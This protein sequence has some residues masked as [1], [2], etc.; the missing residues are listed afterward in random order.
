MRYVIFL[1]FVS[2]YFATPMLY[3]VNSKTKNQKS[4]STTRRSL[5][6]C[7]CCV[8]IR[9][10]FVRHLLPTL[11]GVVL[12]NH[13]LLLSY[14]RYSLPYPT[15]EDVY[16]IPATALYYSPFF[17]VSIIC[18]VP[19]HSHASIIYSSTAALPFSSKVPIW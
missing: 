8:T 3:C 18:A 13:S 4:H 1:L 5:T 16:L 10:A 11:Y 7:A 19:C 12:H 17:A 9:R 14:Y 6:C 15:P 2:S